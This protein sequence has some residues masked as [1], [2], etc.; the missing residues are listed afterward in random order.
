[1]RSRRFAEKLKELDGVRE[2][3]VV[4]KAQ[5]SSSVVMEFDQAQNLRYRHLALHVPEFLDEN[6]DVFA[7][8]DGNRDQMQ[9]AGGKCLFQ[10]RRQPDAVVTRRPRAP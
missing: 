9:A 10:R 6:P 2:V 8:V 4:R 5:R 3:T 1:M 7:V